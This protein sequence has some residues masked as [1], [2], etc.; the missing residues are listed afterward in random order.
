M[1]I[2]KS[3]LGYEN[4]GS[5]VVEII[6]IEKK[7]AFCFKNTKK[8]I[9]MTEENEEKYRSDNIC[10]FSEK[11]IESDKV[12]D[13]CHLTSKYRGPAH[14]KCNFIVTQ[15]QMNFLPFIFQS[16]S[17]YDCHMFFKIIIDKKNDKVKLDIIPKTNDEYILVTIG[18]IKFIDKYRFLSDS[19][20]KLVKTLDEDDFRFL[21]KKFPDKWQY[22]N[23]KLAY[24]YEYFNSKDD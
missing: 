14:S 5:F 15:E 20:D 7:M 4:V 2:T 13:D 23:K 24:P 10:G 17:N 6:K 3:P 18:C 9:N 21:K 8:G 11:N 16:F 12:R 19:L 22:L 1:V